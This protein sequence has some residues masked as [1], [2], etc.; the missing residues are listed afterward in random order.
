MSHF[1]VII[2]V[3]LFL[4]N[5]F[6]KYIEIFLSNILTKGLHHFR[7]QILFNIKIACVHLYVL[8]YFV[9]AYSIP[10]KNVDMFL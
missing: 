9:N 2:T 10:I 7:N 8:N 4:Q 5:N 1:N 6:N 3:I